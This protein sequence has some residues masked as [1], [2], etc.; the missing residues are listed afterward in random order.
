[1][2]M[3]NINE[4]DLDIKEGDTYL[5][6]SINRIEH[7]AP[8]IYRQTVVA[9]QSTFPDLE[10]TDISPMDV[11]RASF[12]EPVLAD[13]AI[14]PL[15]PNAMSHYRFS[16]EGSTP[17]GKYIVNKIKV[18]PKRKS[19]QV[20]EGTLYIIEDLWCLHSLD[21]TNTRIR[22]AGLEHIAG[23][24]KLRMLSL[25]G[26]QVNDAALKHLQGLA[27]LEYLYLAETQVS[28][29]GLEHLK[30]LTSLVHFALSGT[31]VTDAGLKHLRLM[32]NLESLVLED[33]AVSDEGVMKL[34]QAL[35]KCEITH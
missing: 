15:S 23:L 22:G 5:I 20:F 14:S 19:Q 34:Q 30:G 11:V 35:P 24:T 9:Q 18:I 21:L 13:I 8:D 12:Y 2:L 3:R 17:Q 26:T 4:D 32:P 28:D 6:E 33:T 31:R 10:E 1:M 27:S 29:A 25:N 16:Y 7:D